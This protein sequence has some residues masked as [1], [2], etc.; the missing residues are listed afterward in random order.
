MIPL[1]TAA[2]I[3]EVDAHTILNEPIASVDLMERASE[4]FVAAFSGHYPDLDK[5]IAIY[6]GTGNNGGDG[7]AIARLFKAKG[8]KNIHIIIARFSDKSSEDFDVNLKRAKSAKIKIT[9][10][11]IGQE[12]QPE[13]CDII[14]DAL[15]GTGINKPL[16]D[17]YA[18]LVQYLNS[19]HKTTVAVDVPT[20]FYT[21]GEIKKDLLVLKADLVITFQ[22]AKLNFLLPE[23]AGYM[24][25]FEVV[26]IGLDKSYIQSLNSPFQLVQQVD[27]K[28]V[29][30]PRKQFSHKGTYG[31]ALIVAG[32]QQTMGAALLCSPNSLSNSF[33]CG[34]RM[35]PFGMAFNNFGLA[36]KIFK[37]S[38]SITTGLS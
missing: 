38:A 1:L 13:K 14:I 34:V 5:S 22:Q 8:Y 10:I 37:A 28:S 23:S 7:L 17:D 25:D 31:H 36:A 20:G 11:K 24:D 18:R 4:A 3:R 26:E 15:L 9:E 2:Q 32:Q 21:E 16:K 19:L 29:L 30:K 35:L 27:I 12:I 33:M 6:C